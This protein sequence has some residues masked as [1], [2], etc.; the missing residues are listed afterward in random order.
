MI[1]DI[2]TRAF[3]VVRFQVVRIDT[4]RPV[5]WTSCGIL[6]SLYKEDLLY[7]MKDE[8]LPRDRERRVNIEMKS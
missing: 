7:Y 1:R 3:Q 4:G 5:D 6:Q 8:L 2:Q